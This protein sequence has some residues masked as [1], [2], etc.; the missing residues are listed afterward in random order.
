MNFQKRI[1]YHQI[2]LIL[3]QN[4]QKNLRMIKLNVIQKIMKL[5][6]KK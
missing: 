6:M 3:V 4:T 1:Y 2:Y 5:S